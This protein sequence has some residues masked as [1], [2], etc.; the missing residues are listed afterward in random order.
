MVQLTVWLPANNGNA[1]R[2][3][4]EQAL[5]ILTE[6]QRKELDALKIP[7]LYHWLT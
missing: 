3:A 5:A 1:G 7:K 2:T 4:H 6:L